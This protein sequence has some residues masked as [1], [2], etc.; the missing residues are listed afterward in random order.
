MWSSV[1]LQ[2]K[3]GDGIGRGCW[4]IVLIAIGFLGFLVVD[5]L[6]LGCSGDLSVCCGYFELGASE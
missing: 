6:F 4:R 5:S 3:C 1:R 2:S